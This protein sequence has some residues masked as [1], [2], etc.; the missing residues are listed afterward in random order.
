MSENKL[1]LIG[2]VTY[3]RKAAE[4]YSTGRMLIEIPE[5]KKE[6][7]AIASKIVEVL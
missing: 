2:T 3:T 6:F 4:A 1:P 7:E 5:Y